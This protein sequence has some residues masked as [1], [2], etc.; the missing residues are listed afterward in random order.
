[1]LRNHDE[2]VETCN[3]ISIGANY[4][5][6]M[7]NVYCLLKKKYIYIYYESDYFRKK[8]FFFFFSFVKKTPWLESFKVIETSDY[9][10][11]FVCI[12]TIG[13]D[14]LFIENIPL[15]LIDRDIFRFLK[16]TWPTVFDRRRKKRT[17]R[18][19]CV[20][21]AYNSVSNIRRYNSIIIFSFNC[22]SLFSENRETTP[23]KSIW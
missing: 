18:E 4:Q 19:K 12:K 1:M 20:K 13:G 16:V 3:M 22:N 6:R 17:D 8:C 23:S 15:Y 9:R 14:N 5:V 2:F 7:I 11:G 21:I 10:H